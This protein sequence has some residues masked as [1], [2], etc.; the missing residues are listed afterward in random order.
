MK[1]QLSISKTQNKEIAKIFKN[2]V[3]K[4]NIVELVSRLY[5]IKLTNWFGFDSGEFINSK[6]RKKFTTT[7]ICF[8]KEESLLSDEEFA[9]IFSFLGIK[10]RFNVRLASKYMYF[11]SN[12]CGSFNKITIIHNLKLRLFTVIS[13]LNLKKG[14]ST[15]DQALTFILFNQLSPKK[16]GLVK[17]E[18]HK[19]KLSITTP[20]LLSTDAKLYY[21]PIGYVIIKD[22]AFLM[23]IDDHYNPNSHYT[24]KVVG[25]IANHLIQNRENQ[26]FRINQD[27]FEKLEWISK[28]PNI[29]ELFKRIHEMVSPK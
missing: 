20:K 1:T 21:N 26:K 2:N 27:I 17:T 28:Y 6:K 12:Q 22:F 10:E 19:L 8:E 3:A 24:N 25:E 15:F 4:S 16:V 13:N 11:I 14:P 9:H 7:Q 18:E 23:V 29:H 5:E